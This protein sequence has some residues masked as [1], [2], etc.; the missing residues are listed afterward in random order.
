MKKIIVWYKSLS[1]FLKATFWFV[2]CNVMQKG[3][4]MITT[5]I[6]TRLLSTEE[7]GKINTYMSWADIFYI[8]IS[9]SVWRAM[10]N[11]YKNYEDRKKVFSVTIGLSLVIFC[12]WI[13]IFFIIA[14]CFSIKLRMILIVLSLMFFSLSYN[15]FLTW[16]VSMQYDYQY[17][18][19]V[20]MTIIYSGVSSIGGALLVAFIGRTA[21]IKLLPQVICCIAISIY[22]IVRNMKT[23]SLW[24]D[25]NIWRF[26]LSFSLPLIPHYL[27]E[28]VL[29]STDRI[30]IDKMC[31]PSDVAIYSIAYA[32]GSL[33]LVITGAINST[34]APY[35]YQKINQGDYKTLAKN[36]NIIISFVAICVCFLMMFGKEIVIIFGGLKYLDSIV[37][38]I[39]ICLGVFFNYVFQIFARVQE[40]YEQKNTIVIASVSCAV[41]NVFLNYYFIK[42]YGY[43]CAAY[44]T[45]VCYL[46]FCI[47]H[48]FFYR[49][50]CKKNNIG[51]IYDVKTL[52]II[53]LLLMIISVAVF[54]INKVIILKYILLVFMLFMI[55]MNRKTIMVFIK[56][57]KGGKD[58]N[59]ST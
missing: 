45:F 27:S 11:L 19:L 9:L 10:L 41:L 50:V 29:N 28:V 39:P 24:Y 13:I 5:P 17:K 35:Q 58:E 55:I 42:K 15:V 23:N 37:L 18:D 12:F 8:I 47:F 59:T 32:V 54:F 43:Q 3:I 56:D 49:Y 53:S 2:L 30:M 36:T 26:S 20:I 33:S 7:F 51:K 22:I 44:T 25:G 46:L 40:Y 6:F 38:I 21:I 48:Y 1:V 31:G 34:F 57:M 16:T 52:C 4:S 14:I